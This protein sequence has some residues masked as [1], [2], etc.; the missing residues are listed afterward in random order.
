MSVASQDKV[1]VMALQHS[2]QFSAFLAVLLSVFLP[3]GFLQAQP[4]VPARDGTGTVVTPNPNSPNPHQFDVTGGQR[5]GDRANLFHSFERLGLS[6]GQILN[7]LS[8]PE[9]RNILGRVTGGE[10]SFIDGLIQVTGGNSNLFLMNPAGIVFGQNAS[11]NVPAAFTVTTA[12]SIGFDQGGW[13][14]G[15]QENS[16]S[17]LVGNPNQFLFEAQAPGSI[18]NFGKLAV[19]PN[20]SLTL[21]GGTVL[22]TGTLTTPGGRITVAA[23]P[24]ESIVRIGQVG[25]LLSLEISSSERLNSGIQAEGVVPTQA[26][27]TPLS[28]PELLTGGTLSQA[29]SVQVTETGALV[30]GRAEHPLMA[31]Q[32]VTPGTAMI[33]GQ[34]STAVLPDSTGASRIEGAGGEINLLGNQIEVSGATINASG[35]GGGTIRIGGDYQGS[36]SLPNALQTFV[37]PNSLIR[38][39]ALQNGSGGRVIV[40]SEDYTQIDGKISVRGGLTLGNGGFVETSSRGLLAVTNA[41]DLSAPNG[42]GGTWLIDP[43]TIT[44]IEDGA[45][46]PVEGGSIIEVSLIEDGLGVGNTVIIATDANEP[47]IGDINLNASI[48]FDPFPEVN[49]EEATLVFNAANNINIFNQSINEVTET[50][51]LN[52]AFTADI[53]NDGSGSVNIGNATINTANGNFEATGIGIIINDATINT[54]NGS[55]TATGSVNIGNATIDTGNGN[56][57]ATGGGINIFQDTLISTG[58]GAIDLTGTALLGQ[59]N[60]NGITLTGNAQL[61]S[62]DGDINLAGT[63]NALGDNNDGVVI[64]ASQVISTGIGNIAIA[65]TS[66]NGAASEGILLFENGFVQSN[67]G[68][69]QLFGT[70]RGT[71]QS[72]GI[73]INAGGTLFSEGT[74]NLSLVGLSQG[75]GLDN[76]G[77]VLFDQADLTT[78]GTGTI[79]LAGTSSNGPNSQGISILNN[80]LISSASG[81]IELTGTG[82][83]TTSGQGILTNNSLIETIDAGDIALAG[84]ATGSGGN[85]DGILLLS[86][87]EIRAGGIGAVNLSG[88]GGDGANSFGIGSFNSVVLSDIGAIQINGTST[89]TNPIAL[90]LSNTSLIESLGGGAIDLTGNQAVRTG[91]I[92]NP[93]GNITVTSNDGA[94]NTSN[95]VLRS[96]SGSSDGGAITLNAAETL[97][98][99]EIDTRSTQDSGGATS[100]PVTLN[101]GNQIIVTGEIDTSA[102]VGQGGS[103]EL[104]QTTQLTQPTTL[105]TTAGGVSSGTITFNG[106][107]NGRTANANALSLEAGTGTVQFAEPVGDL[108]PVGALTVNSSG[109]TTFNSAVN[110]ASV[111]TNGGG[112]TVLNGNITATGDSGQRYGDEVTLLT[113]L[114]LTGDELDFENAVSGNGQ[115]LTLQPF[116]P[117]QGIT[118]G[119]IETI[120]PEALE[121]TAAELNRLEANLSAITIGAEEQG[122]AINLAGDVTFRS[123][124]VLRAESVNAQGFTLAGTETATLTLNAQNNIVTGDV[125][126]PGRAVNLTSAEGNIDTRGGRVDT[127]SAEVSGGAVT[128][129]APGQ[130]LTGEINTSTRSAAP[131]SQGGTVTF[132]SETP[133]TLGGNLTVSATAGQ[134]GSLNFDAPVVLDNSVTLDT[135]GTGSSGNIRFGNSINRATNSVADSPSLTLDAGTGT[136][137]LF[138]VGNLNP[139]SSL[140]VRTSGTTTLNGNL[141]VNDTL[142]FTGATGGTV[143]TTGVTLTTLNPGNILFNNSPITGV[144]DRLILNAGTGG[145]V[146]LDSVGENGGELA[147]VDLQ[148]GIVSLSGDVFSGGGLDFSR[149]SQVNVIGDTVALETDSTNGALVLTPEVEGPGQ[150]TL[151]AGFGNVTLGTVGNVLPLN[152][153]QILGGNVTGLGPIT[154]GSGGVDVEAEGTTILNNSLFSRGVVDITTDQALT[155]ADITAE[156]LTLSSQ[157][158]NLTTGSLSTTSPTEPGGAITVTAPA[159]AIAT[160]NLTATG[161]TGGAVTIQA[162]TAIRA[163]QIN[164][165]GSPGS[166]GNVILDPLGDIEVGSIRS[167]GGTQGVGGN[168]SITSTSRFFRATETFPTP[169][170]PTGTASLSTGSPNGGGSITIRHAGGELNAPVAAFEVGNPGVNGTAGTITSGTAVVTA[171]TTLPRSATEGNIAFQTDDP[172][173]PDPELP[174]NGDPNG[175]LRQGEAIAIGRDLISRDQASDETGI[176]IDPGDDSGEI[177]F[178][179]SDLIASSDF[180]FQGGNLDTTLLLVERSWNREFEEYLGLTTSLVDRKAIQ[181]VLKR[182]EGETREVYVVV[183]VVAREEQLELI[184]IPSSGSPVRRSVP[185]ATSEKL[186]PVIRELQVSITNP[187]ER[188]TNRYQGPAQQLHDWILQPIAADLQQ[189]GATTLLFSLGPGLRSLPLAALWDGKQFLVEKYSYSLI[190]STSFINT[191]YDSLRQGDILAMGASTFRDQN[192]LPAVPLEVATIA[193]L[194]PSQTFLNESFTL[195]NLKVQRRLTEYDIIHLAT[196]ADFQPGAPKNSYIQ[197]WDGRLPLTQLPNLNWDVPPLELLVL[198]A[199]RTAVGDRQAELGFAGLAVQAGVKSAIASLWYVSDQGTLGLMSEFYAALRTAPIKSIALQQAQVSMIQGK[200]RIESGQLITNQG[201]IPLPPELADIDSQS[202]AHPYY[203]AGFTLIGTPW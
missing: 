69:I 162:E 195:A 101:A 109:P 91:E 188:D 177:S 61:L 200:V 103:V 114:T 142:D 26:P 184:L 110:A 171:P 86:N 59:G 78:S 62:T 31:A 154:V 98:V 131:T 37:D 88:T 121:L 138:T 99:G 140:Q 166:G 159:G 130:L 168:I 58:T 29:T 44:I 148:A 70:G 72:Q 196:H 10:A 54:A 48:D 180:A 42:T 56:F 105:I 172:L 12:N 68:N 7:F 112:T 152:G 4:I 116:T 96:D 22:N 119:G 189:M 57:T 202:L 120:N 30:L 150:L 3:Q 40:W 36:G 115:S 136:V 66:G 89:G 41:P 155:T 33:S 52:I 143:L 32:A 201:S 34:V 161:T 192:P 60:T 134:G 77:I 170:S 1:L 2:R 79:T 16:W 106:S 149:V 67:D 132:T 127:S 141:T 122:S 146:T 46:P 90:F 194:W 178:N 165:S 193:E 144:G 19:A 157:Q 45:P 186:F 51:R 35:N 124:L 65:G 133:V 113:D 17:E 117:N 83:G 169:F 145:T 203:W 9:I 125:I 50:A 163:G 71:N 8:S 187:R 118:L 129:N 176:T 80:N 191:R 15:L 55:F 63:S 21:L 197:L 156:T 182:I 85:N 185:E 74:G 93:G 107:L 173:I 111:F 75:T 167:E 97:T 13:F 137:G 183:Y 64:R 175:D 53:D 181:E 84:T 198:S 49:V 20:E 18:V 153:L 38:A 147:G 100:G 28:L 47:G 126:N 95:G 81:G 39:D 104:N 128:L 123:P 108:V 94:V 164:A 179:P 151:N 27:V 92:N 102:P 87:T 14:H 24:G 158:Q 25:H 5:S 6:D 43:Q 73:L 160:G 199:C 139:L 76:D 174:I 23:V 82:N 135:T 11:L 190:P